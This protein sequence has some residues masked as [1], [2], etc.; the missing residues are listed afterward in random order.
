MGSGWSRWQNAAR[1]RWVVAL[2]VFAIVTAGWRMY[3]W[4]GLAFALGVVCMWALLHMSRVL[5]VLRRAARHPV[6]F[7]ASVVMLQ[8]RLEPGMPL[9]HVLALTQSLGRRLEGATNATE[10]YQ[11]VDGGGDC[12]QCIFSQGKLVQWDLQR[13]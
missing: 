10:A 5:S 13:C 3:G 7:V 12:V 9:L 2:A 1:G 8:S 11:W 4:A 6:G